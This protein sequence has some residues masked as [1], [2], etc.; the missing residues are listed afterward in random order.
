MQ[1]N[2]IIQVEYAMNVIMLQ[3]IGN[4]HHHIIFAPD[5]LS[6]LEDRLSAA[7]TDD[8]CAD[9]PDL[10]DFDFDTN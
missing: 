6:V 9:M 5:T 2:M 8:F 1:N 10:E 3:N 4:I 7:D